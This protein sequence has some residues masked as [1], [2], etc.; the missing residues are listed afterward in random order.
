MKVG[1]GFNL[2]RPEALEAFWYMWRLTRDWRYR[3]WGWQVFQAFQQHSKVRLWEWAGAGAAGEH[4]GRQSPGRGLCRQPGRLPPPALLPLP[5]LP[6]ADTHTCSPTSLRF[7]TLFPWPSLCKPRPATLASRMRL[8]A[9]PPPCLPAACPFPAI[10]PV[11]AEAGYSGIKDVR[12]GAPVHDDTQQSF[13]LAETL[14]YLWLLFRWV[15][16]VAGG[17]LPR[18]WQ[19]QTGCGA[20]G[21]CHARHCLRRR[22]CIW[23]GWHAGS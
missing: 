15:G 14:K 5:L 3:A 16:W 17:V 9:H 4:A 1:A 23:P 2:L 22:R 12:Q 7:C 18:H 21:A 13:F 10:I 20:C 8:P 19:L 11:Q 6:L